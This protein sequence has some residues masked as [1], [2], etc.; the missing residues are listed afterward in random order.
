MAGEIE[1]AVPLLL[2]RGSDDGM[3]T[4]NTHATREALSCGVDDQLDA[5]EGQARQDGVAERSVLPRK[6][7]NV[8]GGKGP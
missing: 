7:S 1:Q 6:P 8:G 2:R 3:Y 4:R 5:R